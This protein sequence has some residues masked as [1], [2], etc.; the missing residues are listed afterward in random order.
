MNTTAK[1]LKALKARK[2]LDAKIAALKRAE[3][4]A[5][6]N[7]GAI[8]TLKAIKEYEMVKTID[9]DYIDRRHMN[10]Y[11]DEKGFINFTVLKVNKNTVT[12]KDEDG[13]YTVKKDYIRTA[14]KA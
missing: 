10:E 3:T 4:L 12:I 7:V 5:N 14:K 9:G 2:A 6:L 1:L 8:V 11:G 13:R